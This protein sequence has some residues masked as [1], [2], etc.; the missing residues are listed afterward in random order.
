MNFIKSI[1]SWINI[2]GL[3]CLIESIL[4]ITEKYTPIHV[5][6]KL[7]G[8]ELKTWRNT[9][10]FAYIILA[11]GCYSFTFSKNLHLDV[12]LKLAINLVG[13]ALMCIGEII[14]IRNN[15][16]KIKKWSSTI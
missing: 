9:R 1:F 2:M 5:K 14:S 12:L 4:I 10:F 11:I 3:I 16:T 15:I 7:E 8:K 6:E 13:L